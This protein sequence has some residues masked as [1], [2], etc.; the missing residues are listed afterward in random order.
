MIEFYKELGKIRK[1]S[2][3]FKDGSF[4]IISDVSGCI[5][6][7]RYGKSTCIMTIANRNNHEIDY[8][9][10]DKWK[11]AEVLLGGKMFENFV[12]IKSDSAVILRLTTN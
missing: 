7:A 10:H 3:C 2:D 12:K 11:N 6:F 9:L 1:E 4:E 8:Y 5:A